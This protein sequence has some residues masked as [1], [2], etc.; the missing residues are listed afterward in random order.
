M[1]LGADM[2]L[3][4]GFRVPCY[5]HA[6]K[7][8]LF[9]PSSTVGIAVVLRHSQEIQQR[10]SA[11]EK[12]SIR[13]KDGLSVRERALREQ[14]SVDFYT[15][16]IRSNSGLS[17]FLLRYKSTKRDLRA[18]QNEERQKTLSAPGHCSY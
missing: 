7:A 12:E 8:C 6:G 11:C 13:S 5:D 10:T 17:L 1:H 18:N 14:A 16:P 4:L 15:L 3:D 9:M 2:A